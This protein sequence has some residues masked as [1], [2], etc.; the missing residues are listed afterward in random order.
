MTQHPNTCLYCGRGNVADDSD[1]DLVFLDL[2]RDIN[3]GDSTYI[4]SVCIQ[5]IAALFDYYSENDVKTLNKTISRQKE[6]I[7]DLRAELQNRNRRLEQISTG[8]KVLKEEKTPTP[9]RKT[10]VPA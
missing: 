1:D 10:K 8:L 4:C 3:W 2:E 6:E 7:H 9:K 5:R